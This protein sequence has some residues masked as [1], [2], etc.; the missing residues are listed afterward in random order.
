MTYRN[1]DM[2][3]C[4]VL[5]KKLLACWI[6]FP[7]VGEGVWPHFSLEKVEESVLVKHKKILVTNTFK[8]FGWCIKC[9]DFRRINHI[10]LDWVY[11]VP[12]PK[13]VMLQGSGTHECRHSHSCARTTRQVQLSKVMRQSRAKKKFPHYKGSPQSIFK[14]WTRM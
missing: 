8:Y 13:K 6:N 4:V 12:V 2:R 10:Y 5:A 14:N 11:Q 1:K 7:Q 3:S 9:Q